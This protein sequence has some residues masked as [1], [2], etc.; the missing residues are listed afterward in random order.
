MDLVSSIDWLKALK[1]SD[2]IQEFYYS[3]E[4][5]QALDIAINAIK[6]ADTEE[7]RLH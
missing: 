7:T 4:F 2:E 6:K 1:D 3:D 5:C